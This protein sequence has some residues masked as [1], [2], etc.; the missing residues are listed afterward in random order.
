MNHQYKKLF[1][2]LFLS[3]FLFFNGQAFESNIKLFRLSPADKQTVNHISR[4]GG[5]ISKFIP[6]HYAEVY[7]SKELYY[8]LNN[9][10]I[11]LVEIPNRA[12]LYADSLIEA[13]KYSANP[14]AGY[15]TY[16]EITDTL[17][18]W[19]TQYSNIA[20][21]HSIGQT[22]MGREMWIMKISD[23]VSVE[24]AEP[25]FK[26]ISTM[27]GD[28]VVGK[29]LM[30]EL[31]RLLLSGYGTDQ[32]ITN[33]VD[34]T[35]I[36][37]MPDMN[38]D[39]TEAGSRFNSNGVDLNRNFPD[40]EYGDPPFPGHPYNLQTETQNVM[41]FTANHNFVLSANF[42]GGALVANYP[43]DKR[44]PGD[45][46]NPP[47][48]GAPDDVTFIDL[49]LTYAER[50]FPMYTS[51]IFTNGIT[52]GAAWYETDGCMQDWNYFTHDCKELTM[53][54]SNIKW[55]PASQLPQFWQDNKES[56]LA[57]MEKVH[58][59][60]K[61]LVTDSLTG[62]PISAYV[63]VLETGTGV[64]T[65]P[66]FGD[67]YTVISPGSYSLAFSANGY[68]D[69]VLYNVQV[70]SF[71]ATI[72]DVQL[73]SEAVYSLDGQVRDIESGKPISDVEV[74][75]S[76]PDSIVYHDTTGFDGIFHVNIK[77]DSYFVQLQKRYYFTYYDTL[78]IQSDSSLTFLMQQIYEA[79]VKGTI[80]SSIGS[81]ASGAIVYCQGVTDTLGETGQ[82]RFQGITPGNVS[83]FAYLFNHKTAQLDT[84]V[85]NHDS[86]DV[87]ILLEP[88]Q[89]EIYD[90]FEDISTVS[91]TPTLD[92]EKGSPT[93]G[94]MGAFSG[95]NL[96]ATNLSGNYSDGGVLSTL[97]S[98]EIPILGLA[99]PT[100]EYYHWY[101]FESGKDGGNVKISIDNGQNW[102]IL[103][104]MENYP[105]AALQPGSGNPLEG[106]PV[107]SGQQ[108]Y[109]KSAT[110]DLNNYTGYPVIKLRFDVGADQAGNAAGW[111]FDDLHLFDG[112]V[113]GINNTKELNK[114]IK[115]TLSNYPNPFNPLTTIKYSIPQKATV[116]VEVYNVIGQKI[117]T[118]VNDQKQAGYHE[119]KFDATNL[120]SGIYLYRM[121]AGNAPTSSESFFQQVKK[122]VVMK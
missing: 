49:A 7:L 57:F 78:E 102:Q 14:M 32:R 103:Y 1:I 63:T 66:D 67:Y 114:N 112:N 37:I 6:N 111:Y 91:L 54:V 121:Q 26:Y 47:Y 80:E 95:F 65:D 34:N 106:E 89:N 60:I 62:L 92:W 68:E 56:L 35:E 117:I 81:P 75:I 29:E 59:G 79:L 15:H 105:I 83:I 44:L 100:L 30:I 36:W 69:K 21:L 23:N 120:A 39:G 8:Q 118:L 73:I 94:P 122:M 27:H 82:F 50:N 84:I 116:I 38:F 12:K 41:H 13:T 93:S 42:H 71:P 17:Q 101:D 98:S 40:R 76:N 24:E 115:P 51:P 97:E 4:L 55:P 10:G 19:V 53:E 33:L 70:D 20:E 96:W 64:K 45:S 113:V 85:Q 99:K 58:T 43:W 104:P 31:I 25:E 119:V 22:V 110:F 87:A 28:E 46:G 18:I 74:I 16:Q 61:G 86:L 72:I 88:G 90:D 5:S 2:F 107:Y 9:L 11:D 3:A 52:N 109:W 108:Q 48:A 77:P